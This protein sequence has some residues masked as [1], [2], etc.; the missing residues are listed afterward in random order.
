MRSI[1]WS[2]VVSSLV[3]LARARGAVLGLFYGTTR[4]TLQAEEKST[5][6]LLQARH[7]SRREELE[8]QFDNQLLHRAQTLASLAQSQWRYVPHHALFSLGLLTAGLNPYGYVL[9]P[10][11]VAEGV[12]GPFAHRLRRE[13][14][15]HIEFAED[16]MP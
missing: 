14:F 3:L 11:W 13:S 1:R 15:F 9:T 12:Q 10:L 2:L 4:Q 7:D 8:E 6:D 5:R 16:V